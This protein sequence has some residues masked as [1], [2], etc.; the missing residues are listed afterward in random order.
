[1]DAVPRRLRWAGPFHRQSQHA[2]ADA[3][4]GLEVGAKSTRVH[5]AR[6]EG[7]TA[8]THEA[9]QERNAIPASRRR[10]AT[11]PWP[12]TGTATDAGTVARQGRKHRKPDTLRASRAYGRP[13][14]RN[15]AE[16]QSGTSGTPCS[17]WRNSSVPFAIPSFL[18]RF[19]TY[20]VGPP[21]HCYCVSGTASAQ[22]RNTAR[23]KHP[24]R[25]AFSRPLNKNTNK[26]N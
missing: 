25:G 2:R 9:N 8:E 12:C 11:A 18:K 22:G 13:V 21:E 19:A 5:C 6:R 26:R 10:R 16:R 15:P 1:M 20:A 3:R 17:R 4:M 23:R 14:F 24:K 7:G